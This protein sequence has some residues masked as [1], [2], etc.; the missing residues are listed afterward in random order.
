MTSSD[1]WSLENGPEPQIVL[2]N[3]GIF[4]DHNLYGGITVF[5]MLGVYAVSS[6]VL[7]LWLLM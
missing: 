6:A 1:T 2:L 5:S 4:A 7:D 3:L